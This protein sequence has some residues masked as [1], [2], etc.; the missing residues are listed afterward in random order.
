[1]QKKNN[2]SLEI[3]H[4]YADVMNI[5]GDR[6]NTIALKFRGK[7][8]GIDCKIAKIERGTHFDPR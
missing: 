7:L 3:A 2:W 6:G 8:H 5:Y 1:M 4:L